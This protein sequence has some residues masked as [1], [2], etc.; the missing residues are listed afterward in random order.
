MLEKWRSVQVL[1]FKNKGDLQSCGNYT[2][3][4]DNYTIKM[5]E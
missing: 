1:I 2:D 5:F 4:A 3:K